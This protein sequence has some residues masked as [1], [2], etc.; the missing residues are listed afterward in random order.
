M[1]VSAL[2][3]IFRENNQVII[4]NIMSKGRYL[5]LLSINTLMFMHVIGEVSICILMKEISN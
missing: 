4:T 5:S 2:I 1:R 3:N